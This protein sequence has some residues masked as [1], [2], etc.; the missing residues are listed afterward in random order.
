MK[1]KL[2]LWLAV[3]TL[4]A[5]SGVTTVAW[6]ATQENEPNYVNMHH[7]NGAII[8]VSLDE[9]VVLQF[10]NDNMHVSVLEQEKALWQID[11]VEM[12]TFSA[13]ATNDI[14]NIVP[15]DN[16]NVRKVLEN[17]QVIIIRD[18]VRYSVLGTPL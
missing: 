12:I 16:N 11:E 17:G 7:T 14:P 2:L 9:Q 6:G 3:A 8:S 10:L 15:N 18:G 13:E 5:G 1:E 4:C